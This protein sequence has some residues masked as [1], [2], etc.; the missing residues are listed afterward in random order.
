[1]SFNTEIFDGKS[2]SDLFSEI[3]KNTDSKRQQINTFIAKIVQLIR[4]PEDAAVLGPVI[5]GFIEVNVKN[6]EHLVR[7]A[8][9]AQRLVSVSSKSQTLDSLLTEE[10]KQNL[11]KDINAE[12]VEMKEDALDIEEDIFSLS[13]RTK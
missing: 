1:M 5:Q 8:Q 7:I 13:K 2:L 12:L 4:T 6:D 10:E 3:H 11:L 9:I